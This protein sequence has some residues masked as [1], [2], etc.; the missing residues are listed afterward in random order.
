MPSATDFHNA[1]S[2]GPHHQVSARD[3]DGAR[4][5]LPVV[6]PASVDPRVGAR[7]SCRTFAEHP[8]ALDHL[9]MMLANAYGKL[10][11]ASTNGI[12]FEHRTVPSAG[13]RYPLELF[14]LARDVEGVDPGC[15]RYSVDTHDLQIGA[16]RPDDAV[17]ATIFL[18]QPYVASVPAIV[19]IAARVALTTEKYGSRGYRYVLIEAGHVGQNL[20]LSAAGLGVGALPIGGF[21]DGELAALLG[22]DPVANPPLYGVA[23]GYPVSQDVA[24]SRSIP[25]D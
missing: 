4:V 1:T 13:A 2:F 8:L 17:L 16:Q 22:N 15:Y 24:V 10:G 5:A 14:V 7:F 20:V 6:H 11:P 3:H 23:L 9:A 19:M 18:D 21:L 12:E 25:N